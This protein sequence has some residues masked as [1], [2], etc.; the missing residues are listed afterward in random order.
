MATQADF[1]QAGAADG[2][3]CTAKDGE[4]ACDAKYGGLFTENAAGPCSTG[5]D[6]GE[7]TD[8]GDDMMDESGAAQLL[9]GTMVL[10]AA[11]LI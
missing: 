10:A 7:S 2:C 5:G 8:G 11:L 6:A 9:A 4:D 3:A 1:D